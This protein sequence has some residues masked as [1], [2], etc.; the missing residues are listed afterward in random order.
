MDSRLYR[1]TFKYSFIHSW[2]KLIVLV[3]LQWHQKS[4]F[5]EMENPNEVRLNDDADNFQIHK[6]HNNKK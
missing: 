2:A 4:K 6:A 3:F 1:I 5:S